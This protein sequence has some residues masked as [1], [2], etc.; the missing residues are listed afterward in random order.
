MTYVEG[1]D[2]AFAREDLV[3]AARARGE[4]LLHSL[5]ETVASHLLLS[6][7]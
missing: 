4:V 3:F 1:A 7:C 6:L 5:Q 2:G